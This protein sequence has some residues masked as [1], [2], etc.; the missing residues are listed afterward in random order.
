MPSLLARRSAGLNDVMSLT[1][2]QN[3]DKAIQYTDKPAPTDFT[4]KFHDIRQLQDAFNQHYSDNYIPA[5]LSC[6]DESMNTWLNKYCPGFMVVERKPHPYGN[7]CHTIAGDDEDEA[8]G[9]P[10]MWR[11]KIQEG[12]DRPK[13]DDGSWAFPSPFKG[14]SK[15]VKLMLEMTEPI[16]GTGKVASMDSG[17]CVSAGILAMHKYGV[18]GQ[19]LIKK[20]GK[21]WPRGVPGD[22]IN[23][24][25]DS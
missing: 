11:C 4:D 15:T 17:F 12:K 16:H 9:R 24:H 23:N 8:K 21:Y 19:V 6:L 2:F 22:A 25:F 13:K 18:F 10:I 7:E 1:R 3:I 20:H 5:W 14:N